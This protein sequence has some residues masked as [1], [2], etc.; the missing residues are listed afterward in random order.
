M[1]NLCKDGV[2]LVEVKTKGFGGER[3]KKAEDASGSPGRSPELHR[4]IAQGG[5]IS[6]TLAG[7]ND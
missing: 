1:R 5:R 7:I 3:P 2:S 4:L 6:V